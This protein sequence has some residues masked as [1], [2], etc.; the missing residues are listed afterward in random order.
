MSYWTSE[1]RLGGWTAHQRCFPFIK[2]FSTS[3]VH[4]PASSLIRMKYPFFRIFMNAL[5]LATT[6]FL[7]LSDSFS[8]S[9]LLNRGAKG[10]T[11][12]LEQRFNFFS[13]PAR[14]HIMAVFGSLNALALQLTIYASQFF[15]AYLSKKTLIPPPCVFF[16][17]AKT[18][19][20]GP[21]D[22]NHALARLSINLLT[23]V[24]LRSR[25]VRGGTFSMLVML[26]PIYFS[27]LVTN[28]RGIDFLIAGT[29]HVSTGGSSSTGTTP[30][31]TFHFFLNN[32]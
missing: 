23:V 3:I 10:D 27:K 12:R 7:R 2:Q 16:G 21:S 22:R 11:H 26:V 1:E 32:S 24:C 13:A 18:L 8:L 14:T 19:V 4:L 9:H 20:C 6:E 28:R 17:E 5:I 31:F 15:I 25:L 29:N 30:Q